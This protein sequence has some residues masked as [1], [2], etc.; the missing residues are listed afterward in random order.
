MRELRCNH[1]PLPFPLMFLAFAVVNVLLLFLVLPLSVL[2]VAP[3][4]EVFLMPVLF[5]LRNLGAT[6]SF[7]RTANILLYLSLIPV[8]HPG[9]V[10]GT[11]I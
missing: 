9:S 2:V 1:S 4:F 6:D 10:H 11:Q 5:V 8:L 3:M 7:L